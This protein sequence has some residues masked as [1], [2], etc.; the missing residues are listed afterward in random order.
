[1]RN[2]FKLDINP[3]RTM[4]EI[5]WG[6]P[7]FSQFFKRNLPITV[8]IVVISLVIAG[9]ALAF[10]LGNIDG[11]WGTIDTDGATCNTWATGPGNTPT[12]Y[13]TTD[14]AIQTPPDTDENQIRY[15]EPADYSCPGGS[16]WQEEF[17]HQS[18]FGFDGNDA[19]GSP[20]SDTPFYL[21]KFTHYNNPI[22]APDNSFEYVDLTVNVPVTCK[23]GVTTTNFSF[24]PHFVLDETPNSEPCDYPGSSIC[25]DKVTVT[26][27]DT[28]TFTCDEGDYTVNILG[29]TTEG[30]NGE[31]CDQSFNSSAVATEFITE[32]SSDN[33]ACLWAEITPPTADI[34]PDKTCADFRLANPYYRIVTTNL[35]PGSARGVQIVDDLPIGLALTTEPWYTSQLTTSS[36]TVDQGSCSVSGQTIT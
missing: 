16:N 1:M 36:G 19:P 24:T 5:R 29:F 17:A 30:L 13:S 35:G 6:I 7:K 26:Q 15:G 3:T 31:N 34:T 18:G 32:E 33:A 28:E 2:I 12:D 14:P 11:T 8:G 23:D 22:Y 27:P 9:V 21:G 25:P 10:T 20:P 4:R